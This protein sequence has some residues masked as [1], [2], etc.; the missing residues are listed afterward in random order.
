MQISAQFSD[1]FF[2]IAETISFVAQIMVVLS[3]YA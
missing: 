1:F 2:F 3:L